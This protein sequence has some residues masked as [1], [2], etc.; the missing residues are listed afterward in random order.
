MIGKWKKSSIP[1]TQNMVCK[2]IIE[3]LCILL[4]ISHGLM[5]DIDNLLNSVLWILS[6]VQYTYVFVGAEVIYSC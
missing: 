3:H 1:E 5:Q 6:Y 2:I 4:Y